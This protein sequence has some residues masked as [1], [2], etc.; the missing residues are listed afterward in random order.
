MLIS[1]TDKACVMALVHWHGLEAVNAHD[2]CL[3]CDGAVDGAVGWCVSQGGTLAQCALIR[4]VCRFT[5][6]GRL[7]MPQ[8]N[9]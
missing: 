7:R 8:R 3:L 6:L 2:R 1:E 4:Q 5:Q 9:R